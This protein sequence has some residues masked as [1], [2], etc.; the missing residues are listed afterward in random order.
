MITKDGQIE[1]VYRAEFNVRSSRRIIEGRAVPYGVPEW[2]SDDGITRYQEEWAFGSLARYE[3]PAMAGRVKLNYTHDDSLLR[4][5]IGRTKHFEQKPDGMYGEWKVDETE[6][7]DLILFK[8]DDLQLRGLS[9]AAKPLKTVERDG[10]TVRA[11]AYL[12]HV[13]LVEEPAFSGAQVLA[14]RERREVPAGPTPAERIAALR[15]LL[16]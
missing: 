2:V 1:R 12:A 11:L 6:L 15:A 3:E 9:I 4:N 13:A 5:W 16:G 7:G 8:V 10:I 14:M